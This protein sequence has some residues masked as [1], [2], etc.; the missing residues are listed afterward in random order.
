MGLKCCPIKFSSLVNWSCFD[1]WWHHQPSLYMIRNNPAKL[2]V[3]SVIISVYWV[4]TL[5]LRPSLHPPPTTPSP[6]WNRVVIVLNDNAKLQVK[7][8]KKSKIRLSWKDFVQE[9]FCARQKKIVD[10]AEAE[11]SI[12]YK[13]AIF[14]VKIFF[15]LIKT[16][17][18]E[19]WGIF[20][21]QFACY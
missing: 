8:K 12:L 1:I 20:A 17:Y 11:N 16:W 19:C 5:L 4:I 15:K 10:W 7:K 6:N 13:F 18:F 14:S 2:Y 3:N 21:Q 9:R